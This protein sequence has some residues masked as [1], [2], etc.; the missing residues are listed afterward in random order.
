MSANVVP[1]LFA[2]VGLLGFAALLFLSFAPSPGIRLRL[3]TNGPV[4]LPSTVCVVTG[5][6]ATL[7][8][9]LTGAAYGIAFM[10][11][12]ASLRVWHGTF[13][14]SVE[15]WALQRS[16]QPFSVTLYN[17]GYSACARVPFGFHFILA[18]W[19]LILGTPAC[20]ILA[21]L[22][23]ARGKRQVVTL[24]K[25]FTNWRNE[26]RGIDISGVHD[27][28]AAE[29]LRL[30]TG[31]SLTDY[32]RESRKF[33]FL[34]AYV[35]KPQDKWQPPELVTKGKAPSETPKAAAKKCPDC[36]KPYSPAEYRPDAEVWI[37][38]GCAKPLPRN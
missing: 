3:K 11:L 21:L 13:P 26:L 22:D 29:A 35:S 8:K 5:K 34:G 15:G 4:T 6:Q 16:G 19:W 37:C 25:W 36:G 32:L 2:T 30:N 20:S 7:A 38:D 9:R 24:N 10:S 1:Y 18:I 17:A 33:R 23:I 28:Y 31:E 14:F 27:A 12:G